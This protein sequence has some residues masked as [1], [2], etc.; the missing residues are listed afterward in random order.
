VVLVADDNRAQRHWAG[1]ALRSVGYD[2]VECASGGELLER[3]GSALM[4]RHETIEAVVTNPRM[5]GITGLQVLEGL[6][7]AH[8]TTPVVVMTAFAADLDDIRAR[9]HPRI[10]VLVEPFGADD[11]I[12]AVVRITL[13]RRHVDHAA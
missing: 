10:E 8:R 6:E 11:L 2:V 5:G 1:A 7:R 13:R 4:N 3:L 9:N 12:T